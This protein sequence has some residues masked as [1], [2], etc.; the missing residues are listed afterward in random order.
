ML[1]AMISNIKFCKMSALVRQPRSSQ[2]GRCLHLA[3]DQINLPSVLQVGFRVDNVAGVKIPVFDKV[4]QNCEA[5]I[6]LLI[7]IASSEHLAGSYEL[8]RC[9]KCSG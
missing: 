9:D 7:R 6:P 8:I 1:R 2:I 5:I 3:S 4:F